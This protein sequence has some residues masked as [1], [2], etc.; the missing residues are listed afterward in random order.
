LLRSVTEYLEE[1]DPR[2]MEILGMMAGMLTVATFNAAVGQP[3]YY[4]VNG[5]FHCC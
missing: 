1:T 4:V 2:L 5:A 3:R